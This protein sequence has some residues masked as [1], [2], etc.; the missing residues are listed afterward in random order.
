VNNK[1]FQEPD[2]IEE[3]SVK[4]SFSFG[5]PSVRPARETGHETGAARVGIHDSG[6]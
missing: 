5:I 2:S 6:D 1:K 4:I 3:V